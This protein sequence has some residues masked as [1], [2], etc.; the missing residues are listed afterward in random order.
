MDILASDYPDEN[1]KEGRGGE[2]TNSH[3]AKRHKSDSETGGEDSAVLSLG[4]YWKTGY[5]DFESKL[6][7]A[8]E[9]A[10]K[11]HS[12]FA[13]Y[14][15][16]I[17]VLVEPAGIKT[18]GGKGMYYHYR[19]KVHGFTLKIA[20]YKEPLEQTP[21]VIVDIRSTLLMRCGGLF[22]A[23]AELRHTLACLGGYVLWN[24]ITRLDVC[25]DLPG[26]K[27]AKFC[28]LIV[29]KDQYVTRARSEVSYREHLESR[30]VTIGTGQVVLRIYDKAYEVQVKRPDATKRALMESRRWGSVQHSAVRV[31]YQLRRTVLKELGIGTIGEYLRKRPTVGR[32]LTEHW[33]RITRKKPDRKNGNASRAVTHQL[34][35]RVQRHFEEWMGAAPESATRER[36]LVINPERQ[37]KQAAGCLMNSVVDLTQEEYIHLDVYREK[38]HQVLD[39]HLDDLSEQEYIKRYRK[40]ASQRIVRTGGVKVINL[41]RIDR[42]LPWVSDI[43]D[44]GVFRRAG[45]AGRVVPPREGGD[46]DFIDPES[47]EEDDDEESDS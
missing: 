26:V 16:D 43:V 37:V 13:L 6:R 31:E 25:A 15:D 18:G 22:H 33:F 45:V 12:N 14:L 42:P 1:G 39:W 32:Y 3:H 8:K 46:S 24:K 36:H 2:L 23:W 29:Q 44:A 4:V 30:G 19:V 17:L 5:E 7:W 34:W 9:E 11:Q 40:K 20:E 35:Q 10:I 38:I 27:V 28:S 47:G 21:N 41:E